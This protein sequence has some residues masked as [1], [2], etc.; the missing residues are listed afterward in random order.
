MKKLLL[1]TGDLATGKS[2]FANILSERYCALVLRKDSVKEVLGESIDFA[3]RAEN[4]KLSR[5][6]V[7]L[8]AYMFSENSAFGSNMILE[9]NFRNMELEK[10]HAIAAQRNYDVL[11]LVLRGDDNILH[12]R[13]LH[14]I[15]HE[16]RHPVHVSTGL[17]L[18]EDFK[19]YMGKLRMEPIPGQTLEIDANDFS[20]Q[21]DSL[22][23]KKID[24]FM[25]D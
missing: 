8:M 13:Y 16:N 1:I 2:T 12:A 20:Y 23:L 5:A 10:L 24:F 9:A 25:K 6:A 14:R 4:I 7:E 21:S 18:L 11:T 22:I 19:E 17:D 3:D 15:S